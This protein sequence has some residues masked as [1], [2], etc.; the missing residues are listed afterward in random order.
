MSNLIN[1]I[2]SKIMTVGL[3]RKD[4]ISLLKGTSPNY[5]VMDKIPKD[6]GSY[7]G[8]FVDD[9]KW[10]NIS[11]NVPYTDEYLYELYLMCKNSWK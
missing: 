10:N 4:I 8:G 7:V 5:S 6:L 2:L 9:W 1:S 11:E 3:D